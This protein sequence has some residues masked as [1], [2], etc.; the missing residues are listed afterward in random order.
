GTRA[1]PRLYGR[2]DQPPVNGLF[3]QR[4]PGFVLTSPIHRLRHHLHDQRHRLFHPQRPAAPVF[5]PCPPCRGGFA[6]V[7]QTRSSGA[8]ACS[9][10]NVCGTSD[11]RWP[12]PPPPATPRPPRRPRR[13]PFPSPP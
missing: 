9:W 13:A 12:A 6:A 4:P 7:R 8:A 3:C 11:G 2:T 1:L 10:P 5:A